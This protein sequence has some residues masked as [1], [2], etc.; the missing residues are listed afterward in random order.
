MFFHYHKNSTSAADV[1]FFG[2]GRGGGRLL[3]TKRR[4]TAL[5]FGGDLIWRNQRACLVSL[6]IR[7]ESRRSVCSLFGL[8]T[9]VFPITAAE[10]PGR[11]GEL[12]TMHARLLG[13]TNPA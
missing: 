1:S 2:G 9:S 8:N 10:A 11:S 5:I 7:G 3:T 12:E 13:C 6:E 4:T